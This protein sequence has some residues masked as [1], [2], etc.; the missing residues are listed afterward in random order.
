M[1]EVLWC[2]T[3]AEGAAMVWAAL[4]GLFGAAGAIVG[5]V[6][7]GLKQSEILAKQAAI[8][9]RVAG[10]ASTRLS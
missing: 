2:H 9:E 4:I 6:I 10:I 5:A 1:C 3:T 8:A 7:V